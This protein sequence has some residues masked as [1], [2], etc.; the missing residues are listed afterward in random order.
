MNGGIHANAGSGPFVQ[1]VVELRTR[2]LRE[3][4]AN[5]KALHVCGEIANLRGRM[6]LGVN[7][8]MAK[9]PFT[10]RQVTDPTKVPIP[11]STRR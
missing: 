3:A 8:D 1:C 11:R 5:S 7:N 2:L 10:F 4:T 9:L 6:R